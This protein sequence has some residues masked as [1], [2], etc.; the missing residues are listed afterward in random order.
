MGIDG[1]S[2]RLAAGTYDLTKYQKKTVNVDGKQQEVYQTGGRTFVVRNGQLCE[3]QKL[4]NG[5][6][7]HSAKYSAANLDAEDAAANKAKLTARPGDV[8]S[9]LEKYKDQI[10]EQKEIPNSSL[11]EVKLKDG[12]TFTYDKETKLLTSKSYT[13]TEK[14]LVIGNYENIKD[15]Q[16]NITGTRI[17]DVSYEQG[18]A[19]HSLK[20]ENGSLTED[21]VTG[22]EDN[23][24]VDYTTDAKKRVIRDKKTGNT[25][26]QDTRVPEELKKAL[27][28][29]FKFSDVSEINYQYYDDNKVSQAEI[30]FNDGTSRKIQFH[31]TDAG[32]GVKKDTR[33]DESGKEE[34]KTYNPGEKTWYEIVTQDYGIKGKAEI[35]Q[36]IGQLKAA[37]GVSNRKEIKSPQQTMV[38]RNF[39]TPEITVGGKKYKIGQSASDAV[40]NATMP[41]EVSDAKPAESSA[42]IDIPAQITG[43]ALPKKAPALGEIPDLAN[44][45]KYDPSNGNTITINGQN[46]EVERVSS[47]NLG[48]TVFLKNG[49][50]INI[51]Y[52]DDGSI[53]GINL[54]N[55]ANWPNHLVMRYSA[56]GKPLG[57]LQNLY[58]NGDD[59]C[60]GVVIRNAQGEVTGFS[61]RSGTEDEWT[62]DCFKPDGTFAGRILARQGENE[63]N[64]VFYDADGQKAETIPK[65]FELL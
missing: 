59:T 31:P 41:E 48:K 62:L 33:F 36:A 6:L 28:T 60:T 47:D 23:I 22:T 9:L 57:S 24:E 18:G 13:D 32:S 52:N 16:G 56:D 10:A 21:H 38:E 51:A 19:H 49:N 61:N 34:A 30:K 25:A 44:I 53:K 8:T 54:F 42:T 20:Y 39:N 55:K 1:T 2:Q 7:F 27:G 63:F 40:N 35:Y 64:K 12:K 5:N 15:A 29:D 46:F 11:I 50:Q 3:I 17:S 26:F 37:N 4:K 58:E 45:D 65:E 14:G 43:D